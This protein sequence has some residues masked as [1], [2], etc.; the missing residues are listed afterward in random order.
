MYSDVSAAA[1]A[2]DLELIDRIDPTREKAAEYEGL[3]KR[4]RRLEEALSPLFAAEEE[5]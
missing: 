1:R 4:Y 5:T 3:Y 2:A